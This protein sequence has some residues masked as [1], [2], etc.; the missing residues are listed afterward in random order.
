MSTRIVVGIAAVALASLACDGRVLGGGSSN[1]SS[2]SSDGTGGGGS[3]S[4]SG[5]AGAG[6]S[7]SGGSTGSGAGGGA[8]GGG[9]GPEGDDAVRGAGYVTLISDDVEGTS[10]CSSYTVHAFFYRGALAHT[11]A[12]ARHTV[13]SCTYDP[14]VPMADLI[15]GD[16]PREGFPSPGA[17]VVSGDAMSP[18]SVTLT[19]IADGSYPDLTVD[20]KAWNGG[21]AIALQWAASSGGD[22]FPAMNQV[23]IAPAYAT[24]TKSSVP[25]SVL[26]F[27]SVDRGTDLKFSWSM[28]GPSDPA[29][30]IVFRMRGSDFDASQSPTPTEHQVRCEFDP[31]AGA[32]VVPGELLAQMPDSSASYDM[33][34]SRWL[35]VIGTTDASGGEWQIRYELASN[36]RDS[37]QIFVAGAVMFVDPLQAAVR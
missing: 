23:L 3:G 25:A 35:D 28:Q 19:P 1:A 12:C 29:D 31:S 22:Q 18:A 26:G 6:G 11:G 13:G 34:S 14:C 7:G 16:P 10:C 2:V 5:V 4:A 37:S 20:T 17:I 15:R 9:G 27:S 33:V 32:G 21:D 24:L 36:V 8:N 30:R